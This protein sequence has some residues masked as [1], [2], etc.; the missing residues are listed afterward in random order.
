MKE[1]TSEQNNIPI[2]FNFCGFKYDPLS[3]FSPEVSNSECQ[4]QVWH[5]VDAEW[6]CF[7]HNPTASPP[8][9]YPWHLLTIPPFKNQTTLLW[10]ILLPC[11]VAV[12]RTTSFKYGIAYSCFNNFASGFSNLYGWSELSKQ[13]AD[14]LVFT[15]C[16]IIQG[17]T[18]AQDTSKGHRYSAMKEIL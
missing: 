11:S 18:K 2:R 4:C 16:F 9:P 17:G 15:S 1:V 14:H 7:F 8:T 3:P 12:T 10:F 13:K 6:R 5:G